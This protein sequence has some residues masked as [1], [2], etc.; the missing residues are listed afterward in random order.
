MWSGLNRLL[1]GIAH[2]PM[3]QTDAPIIPGNSGGPLVDRCGGVVGINTLISE[4]AQSIRFAVPINA[5]K[6][7]LRHLRA[8]GRVVPPWLGLPGRAS[9]NK[10]GGGG[11]MP[12]TPGALGEGAPDGGA[13]E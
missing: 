13:A 10:L 12:G 8:V 6:S 3:I 4:D 7:I 2:E 1:P 9:G 11:R 5:A